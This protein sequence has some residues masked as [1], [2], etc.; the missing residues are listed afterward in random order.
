MTKTW[1]TI[2]QLLFQIVT[3][4]EHAELPPLKFHSFSGKNIYQGVYMF[5][6]QISLIQLIESNKTMRILF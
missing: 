6:N 1:P 3:I 5:G 4:N 2:S